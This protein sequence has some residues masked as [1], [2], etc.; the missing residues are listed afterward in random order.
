MRASRPWPGR[1]ASARQRSLRISLVGRA[2]FWEGMAFVPER[3]K[4][5]VGLRLPSLSD[6]PVG[7]EVL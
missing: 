1:S 2:S 5:S 3:G 7:D 6:W 4:P